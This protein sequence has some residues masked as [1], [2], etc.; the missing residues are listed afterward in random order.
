MA[1]CAKCGASI[2]WLKFAD[3]GRSV[4]VDDGRRPWG[5]IELEDDGAHVVRGE[6]MKA[7]FVVHW[8]TCEVAKKERTAAATERKRAKAAAANRQ[9]KLF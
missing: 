7:R 8:A 3:T 6:L 1:T 9:T 2:L 5:T 4:P